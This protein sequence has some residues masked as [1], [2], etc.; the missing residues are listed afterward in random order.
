[1]RQ[2]GFHNRLDNAAMMCER[3]CSA[4]L[5]GQRAPSCLHVFGALLTS[6]LRGRVGGRK[7]EAV[8]YT[9]AGSSGVPTVARKGRRFGRSRGR[10]SALWLGEKGEGKVGSSLA[11]G[12]SL[13][14]AD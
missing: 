11:N 12:S 7:S 8:H 4:L 13:S 6:A 5:V 9:R 3:R 10:L 14:L 2:T 1:M